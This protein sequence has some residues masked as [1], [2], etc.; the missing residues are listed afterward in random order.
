MI[1]SLLGKIVLAL[2]A[3]TIF[4]LLLVGL[5][6]RQSLQRGF[7]HYVQQ[8][9]EGQLAHLLPEVQEWY[10]RRGSWDE[11]RGN[12]RR[13]LRL[14]ARARPEGILPP[15]DAVL[16]EGPD[17]RRPPGPGRGPNHGQN[18]DDGHAD[19][20]PEDLH[21]LWR[22]MFL[23]DAD[24]HWVVGARSAN[25][26]SDRL[27][28]VEV[29]GA[30]VGWIGFVP[31][32]EPAGPEAR[33]FLQFQRNTLL[34]SAGFALLAATLLGFLLARHL[35]RPVEALRN[36]V[37]HLTSGDYSVRTPAR[38]HDEIASLGRHINRL[39]E[40]LQANESARRRWTADVAHELRTPVTILLAEIEAVRDGVRPN[41]AVTLASLHEEVTHLSALVDDLQLLALADA[42]A[43]NMRLAEVDVAALLRQVM[44]Y[45]QS[46]FSQAGLELRQRVPESLVIEADA[47]RLRQLMLNLLEN[48]CRYT[49]AGGSVLAVLE[50]TSDGVRLAVEDTAPGLQP[51][52]AERLFERF[53]RAEGSRNRAGGGSGLGLAICREIVLAHSGSIEAQA[54]EMGG[55]RVVVRLPRNI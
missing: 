43:L 34:A 53:Y 46:R 50:S 38:G 1:N 42:G 28:A 27:Q 6:Q 13:W 9:E 18:H 29:A 19:G 23:L 4:A 30:T 36:S 52:Q 35:T 16:D 7:S 31:V 45:L 10:G 25:P 2:L 22:R 11:L 54:S 44:E 51:E 40:T 49:D 37:Q 55:L 21:R 33:R 8:H 17:L 32:P 15:E 26:A 39:A 5:I 12:T 41:T 14:L 3:S 20:P 24:H 47:Q 48:S